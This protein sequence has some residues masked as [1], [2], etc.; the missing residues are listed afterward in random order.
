MER[1]RQL[2]TFPHFQGDLLFANEL[3]RRYGGE[4]IVST[5]LNP[6]M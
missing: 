1:L 3:A 2:I 5:S 4:G 6:G